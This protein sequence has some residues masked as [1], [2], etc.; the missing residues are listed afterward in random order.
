MQNSKILKTFVIASVVATSL[1]IFHFLENQTQ[2]YRSQKPEPTTLHC[3]LG[4]YIV[5]YSS[6]QGFITTVN[7]NDDGSG[8]FNYVLEPNKEG[9]IQ[10]S[11]KSNTLEDSIQNRIEILGISSHEFFKPELL[12]LD[13]NIVVPDANKNG[14]SII[15]QDVVFIDEYNTLVTY[16]IK[17]DSNR[18]NY[19]IL[20][21]EICFPY[22]LLTIG[23]EPYD[24]TLPKIYASGV[25]VP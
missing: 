2:V 24:G 16:K 23:T 9:R 11:Y 22:L 15:T 25:D 10:I 12:V 17:S 8:W 4:T 19:R 5:T 7:R 13:E 21:P 1:F 14:P 3:P 6:D 20:L 18:Q